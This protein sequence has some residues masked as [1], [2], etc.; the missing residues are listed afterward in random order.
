[1]SAVA[2]VCTSLII[3]FDSPLE[4]TVNRLAEIAKLAGVS[5]ATVSRALTRPEMVADRTRQ[6][7]LNAVQATGFRPNE[8]ARSLK[9]QDSRTIGLVVTDLNPFHATLVKAGLRRK[10][11]GTQPD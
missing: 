8:L 4:V 9:R 3:C 7:V 6:R 1:M 11:T 5:A 10:E 2:N